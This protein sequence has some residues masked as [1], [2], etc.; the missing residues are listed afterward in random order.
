M[1]QSTGLKIGQTGIK[2]LI[3]KKKLGKILNLN[4][5]TPT[6]GALYQTAKSRLQ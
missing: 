4:L 5:T 2:N 6:C 3:K 1:D